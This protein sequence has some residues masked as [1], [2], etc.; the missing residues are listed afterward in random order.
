M[1]K[2]RHEV[3]QLDLFP[4]RDPLPAC[5][6]DETIAEQP[7]VGFLRVLRL[8]ALVAEVLQKI[9]DERISLLRRLTV[10][11]T[12]GFLCNTGRVQRFGVTR[13]G[14]FDGTIIARVREKGVSSRPCSSVAWIKVMRIPIGSGLG[15]AHDDSKALWP[16]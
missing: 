16:G 15:L 9:F 5:P 14:K 6:G 2:E 8:P 10:N 12:S 11:S 4:V 1:L 3:L 7:G 13:I